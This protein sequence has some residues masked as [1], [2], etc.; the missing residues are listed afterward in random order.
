MIQIL[1]LP[2]ISSPVS[3]DSDA[4]VHWFSKVEGLSGGGEGVFKKGK[5]QVKIQ[6]PAPFHC[7]VLKWVVLNLLITEVNSIQPCGVRSNISLM[8]C[9]QYIYI[10]FVL[11]LHSKQA[12][13][14]PKGLR[15]VRGQRGNPLLVYSGYLFRQ[16][17][18]CGSTIIWKCV[19]TRETNCLARCTT[20]KDAVIDE[21]QE[22]NHPPPTDKI[23]ARELEEAYRLRNG[24]VP[25]YH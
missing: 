7:S 18:D 8:P 16:Q 14:A 17:H 20:S 2:V 4:L 5:Q 10:S 21:E 1:I 13:L 24:I 15:Y 11:S 23:R 6:F 25:R 3:F 19:M 9:G 12:I 22:H